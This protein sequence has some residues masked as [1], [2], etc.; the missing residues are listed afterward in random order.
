MLEAQ[1]LSRRYGET[2]AVDNVSFTIDSGEIVGLLGHNGAGKTTIMRMLSGYLEPSGGSIRVGGRDLATNAHR[3]Q[4]ELGYLPENL[5]VY[6]DMTVAEYLENA[7][8]LKGIPKGQRILAM[9]AALGAT[10]LASRAL[11]PIGQLSRGMKQ[12]VGVAQ[13]ILG[14]PALLI[15]D[16]P[17][18]GLDP[19]QTVQMRRLVR[20]LAQRATVIL[21]THILQEVDALC[22]RVLILRQGRL[23]M[24]QTLQALRDSRALMVCTDS[25]SDSLPDLLRRMP[26]VASVRQLEE[27]AGRLTFLLE[28]HA[29]VDRDTAASNVATCVVNAGARLYQLQS[30][31]RR[32]ESV[33]REVNAHAG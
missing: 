14:S 6:P 29:E 21:S 17:T 3:I 27:Q 20:R 7:A 18:N 26:Q 1:S 16:E 4:M 10:E 24:D 11:S 8:T 33:F 32:L 2:L 9:R 13:A 28:L 5:P 22:D 23:A 31:S 25:A 15:L 12:R 19:E 30:E